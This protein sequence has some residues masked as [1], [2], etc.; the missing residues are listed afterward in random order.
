MEAVDCRG[1]MFALGIFL[2]HE[3][4]TVL[5]SSYVR[6]EKNEHI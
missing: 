2:P 6:G 3:G 1:E 5:Y 4:A